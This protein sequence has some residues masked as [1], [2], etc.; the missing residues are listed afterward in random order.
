MDK[1]LVLRAMR[2]RQCRFMPYIKI[3]CFTG[4]IISRLIPAV[5]SVSDGHG[6]TYLDLNW[7]QR[8]RMTR[9]FL[10]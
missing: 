9:N 3:R 4:S 5:L 6:Y 1:Q 8:L 10:K 7:V 2:L